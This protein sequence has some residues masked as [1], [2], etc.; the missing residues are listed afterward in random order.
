MLFDQITLRKQHLRAGGQLA[1]AGV[2]RE[3]KVIRG[4]IVAKL[5]PFKSPGRGE[6]DNLAL[7]SILRLMSGTKQG[8]RARYGH[9]GLADSSEGLGTF[10]G[11]AR[12]P[13]LDKDGETPAVRADLH[14]DETAFKTPQGDLA[15]YV[16]DLAESDPEALSSSLALWA[17]LQFR[18]DPKTGRQQL[19]AEGNPLPPLW[20]PTK[21]EATDIVGIGDAVDGLLSPEPGLVFPE[22]TFGEPAAGAGLDPE[23][24]SRRWRFVP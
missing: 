12:S 5:G 22:L 7:K 8:L 16:M 9:P 1:P 6:F 19:D 13:R 20:R 24:Y 23:W 15:G 10:L 18:I 11:R 2:D 21:L 14:F 4:M 3:A 17:D